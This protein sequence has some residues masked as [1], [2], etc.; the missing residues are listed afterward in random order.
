MKKRII[1]L[2]MATILAVSLTSFMAS[3][4]KIT[5]NA[6]S[7]SGILNLSNQTFDAYQIYTLDSTGYS[8]TA[9]F[10]GIDT[11]LDAKGFLG[12]FTDLKGYLASKEGSSLYD[13]ELIELSALIWEFIGANDIDPTKSVIAGATATTVDIDGLDAGYYLVYGSGVAEDNQSVVAVCSLGTADETLTINLKADAPT[14]TKEVWNHN[15]TGTD[16]WDEWTDVEMGEVNFRLTSKVPAM[17]GYDRYSFIIHDV[18]SPGLTFDPT[19]VEV[20]IGTSGVPLI[21]DTDYIIVETGLTD[22]CT[23]EIRF[24][25]TKFAQRNPGDTIEIFYDATLNGNAVIGNPGNPNDVQ[26][27]YSNDPYNTGTFSGGSGAFDDG[28]SGGG[29]R[30]RTPWIR[31]IVYTFEI[32]IYKYTGASL[33][34]T[35]LPGA[36][37]SLLRA[38][39]DDLDDAVMLVEISPGLYRVAIS[40]ADDAIATITS[41]TPASGALKIKG[42]DAGTYYLFETK[43]PDSYNKLTGSIE[44]VI[45]HTSPDLDGHFTVNGSTNPINVENKSGVVFPGSGGIGRWIFII[46]GVLLM[47]GA[48]TV[49]FIR[50]RVK[51]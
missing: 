38:D 8:L 3:A 7:G 41:V 47:A 26:L 25:A 19:S 34:G 43:A 28:T 39:N 6:P 16:K 46:V 42:L 24:D 15:K 20:Y 50:R 33:P 12:T 5:I 29:T 30:G 51:G 18:M 23:F 48:L 22:G 17:L 37:F 11:F 49:L 13:A 2:I 35:A 32:D 40:P 27:E 44:V 31:V 1:G 4:A 21:E 9:G 36:E 14:I 45:D 10:V